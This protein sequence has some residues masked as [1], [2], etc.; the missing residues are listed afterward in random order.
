M[1][2]SVEEADGVS[3]NKKGSERAGRVAAAKIH[4]SC[5][6]HL[7]TFHILAK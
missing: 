3:V 2:A 5:P 4:N 6:S 1:A 7:G